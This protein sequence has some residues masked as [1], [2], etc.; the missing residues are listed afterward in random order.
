MK[1]EAQKLTKIERGI[2]KAVDDISA[3]TDTYTSAFIKQLFILE[4]SKTKLLNSSKTIYE[5]TLTNAIASYQKVM[6]EL[7]G[8][9]EKF[10]KDNTQ[11]KQ[12][13]VTEHEK[14][15]G[16][17]PV[18]A[19]EMVRCVGEMDNIEQQIKDNLGDNAAVVE[20]FNGKYQ[21][22]VN[23]PEQPDAIIKSLTMYYQLLQKRRAQLVDQ[24][25]E[26]RDKAASLYDAYKEKFNTAVDLLNSRCPAIET[27]IPK[28]FL[29]Y[30]SDYAKSLTEIGQKLEEIAEKIT[31]TDDVAALTAKAKICRYELPPQPF[32]PIELPD[33]L[34]DLAFKPKE[35]MYGPTPVGI[36]RVVR[37]YKGKDANQLSLQKGQ[38]V[39]LLETPSKVW[40]LSMIPLSK[41]V[42]FAPRA[43]IAPVGRGA[44]FAVEEFR[45]TGKKG[46]FLIKKGEVVALLRNE[47]K[48]L[49]VETLT[50]NRGRVPRDAFIILS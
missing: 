47:E 13:V 28:Q 8:A 16:K 41:R 46:T 11:F 25:K 45:V 39:Y 49:L 15:K 22:I 33:S 4:A 48:E 1:A 19:T 18:L 43:A 26:V 12:T 44:A 27:T 2:K 31:P 6:Q 10:S 3:I 34:S 14:Y 23:N 21:E 20:N 32:K 38:S 30:F 36:A 37:P 29:A 40:C 24:Q 35:D 17:I 5:G 50:R 7:K 9:Q 42:A